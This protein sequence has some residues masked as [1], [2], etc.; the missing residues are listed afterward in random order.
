M[1][2]SRLPITLTKSLV[3]RTRT[4]HATIV[5]DDLG[6]HRQK[7]AQ[8]G[9]RQKVRARDLADALFTGMRKHIERLGKKGADQ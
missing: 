3:R 4:D 7:L 9:V 2:T 8:D 6:C 5:R 1:P